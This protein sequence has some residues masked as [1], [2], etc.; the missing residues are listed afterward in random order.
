[1]TSLGQ[2]VG[3]SQ[4]VEIKIDESCLWNEDP[5]M[6]LLSFASTSGLS[7]LLFHMAYNFVQPFLDENTLS[8]VIEA[9]VR[10]VTPA[11]VGDVVAAGIRVVDVSENK[12]KFRGIIMKGETKILEAE[13][14]RC[15]VSRNYLR[16]S[17]V[18]KAT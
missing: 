9:N 4:T 15:V 6:S 12:I 11:H 10:H 3:K 14:V 8:V 16:R 2:L 7:A 17:S 1:M 18:E 13:F 5:E